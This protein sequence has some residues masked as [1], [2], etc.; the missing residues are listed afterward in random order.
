MHLITT[1][2]V[3]L[4]KF[5]WYV[6]HKTVASSTPTICTLYYTKSFQL[7]KFYWA[8]G[9][10]QV[11]CTLIKVSLPCH[12]CKTSSSMPEMPLQIFTTKN[13]QAML[14]QSQN[15]P[16]SQVHTVTISDTASL[17]FLVL[18]SWVVLLVKASL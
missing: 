17:P 6:A 18:L 5:G 12:W 7:L 1:V 10:L 8:V 4:L 15:L 2:A 9:A 11:H 14:K 13:V 3:E 16:A